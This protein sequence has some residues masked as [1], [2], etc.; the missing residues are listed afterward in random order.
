MSDFMSQIRLQV[1]SQFNPEWHLRIVAFVEENPEF[2]ILLPY[3]SIT[4]F[5]FGFNKNPDEP[6]NQEAP[7]NIFETL[8][9]SI[10][11]SGVNMKY[12]YKQYKQII[13]YLR[14][15]NYL[16]ED[17]VFPFKVQPKKQQIYKD[18]INILLRND[19]ITSEMTLEHLEIV[20]EVKGIGITTLSL[21]HRLYGDGQ[22]VPYSDRNF[23]KGFCKLYKKSNVS[24]GQI[25]EVTNKWKDKMVGTMFMYQCC[26]YY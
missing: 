8:I 17:M 7:R 6:Y 11:A 1:I 25:I 15:V 18:L 23:I 12:G 20:K 4:E 5:E 9:Y 2:E 3:A 21:C 10:A 13:G 19:I 26:H 14:S 24:E 22:L 16:E